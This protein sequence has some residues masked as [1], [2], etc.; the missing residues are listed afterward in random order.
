MFSTSSD[1]FDIY[2][3]FNIQVKYFKNLQLDLLS[4]SRYCVFGYLYFT[5]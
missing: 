5:R 1:V 3:Y 2:S 4:I